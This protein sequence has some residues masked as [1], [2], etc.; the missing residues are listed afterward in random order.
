MKTVS[1]VI[2]PYDVEEVFKDVLFQFIEKAKSSVGINDLIVRFTT[3]G[4]VCG[5]NLWQRNLKAMSISVFLPEG[6]ELSRKLPYVKYLSS[7]EA[8]LLRHKSNVNFDDKEAEDAEAVISEW[9]AEQGVEKPKTTAW[10][11]EPVKKS[12]DEVFMDNLETAVTA[13]GSEKSDVTHIVALE[14]GISEEDIK[15]KV[16]EWKKNSRKWEAPAKKK[17]TADKAQE[18]VRDVAELNKQLN[19]ANEE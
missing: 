11:V 16:E 19:E 14:D 10:K 17:F 13:D 15:A 6:H 9:F 5:L 1:I 8:I 4:E 2:F 3:E 7:K 18:V 12:L